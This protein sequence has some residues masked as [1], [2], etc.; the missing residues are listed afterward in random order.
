MIGDG[1]RNA[2]ISGTSIRNESRFTANIRNFSKSAR[3]NILGIVAVEK[4]R[5]HVLTFVCK[6][7]IIA[8][9]A[10]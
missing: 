9:K 6:I 4:E 10:T 5:A 8:A 1:E 2:V 3:N 7:Y